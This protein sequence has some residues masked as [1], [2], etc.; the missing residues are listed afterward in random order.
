MKLFIAVVAVIIVLFSAF[1][2]AGKNHS[3]FYKIYKQR[4]FAAPIEGSPEIEDESQV[5]TFRP[6]KSP[7]P[8]ASSNPDDKIE[9]NGFAVVSYRKSTICING[10]CETKK[11]INGNCEVTKFN[12][13]DESNKGK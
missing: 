5:E 3:Y 4:N 11:C 9:P 13:N 10:E 8:S 2:A 6:T 1:A 12:L 7:S